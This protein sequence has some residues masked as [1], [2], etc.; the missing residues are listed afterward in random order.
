M[1]FPTQLSL[2]DGLRQAQNDAAQLKT[3]CQQV[4]TAT[5]AGAVSA[6]LLVEVFWRLV[7]VK[8]RFDLAAAVSGMAAY[9]QAQLGNGSLDIAAEFTAMVAAVVATREWM[10][11]HFPS[12]GGYI[13]KDQLTAAG[14]VV[15]QFSPAE[16]A[17]LRTQLTA[18][19][20]T[21]G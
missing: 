1:A 19:I 14:V 8:E 18:L 13:L 21:I 2:Q 3:Y 17:G 7:Q 11:T 5:A 10:I 9:A 15:R 4:S 6:N 20:A 12:N 16:T